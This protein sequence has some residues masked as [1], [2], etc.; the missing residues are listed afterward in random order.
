MREMKKM[1]E[2]NVRKEKE[3]AYRR[4]KEQE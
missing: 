1:Q 3:I 2:E 4:V